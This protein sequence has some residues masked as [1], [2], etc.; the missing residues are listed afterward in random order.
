MSEVRRTDR[1]LPRGRIPPRWS[2]CARHAA[3]ER[4]H[5]PWGSAP[6]GEISTGGRCAGLPS[7]HHPPSEFLTLST[8]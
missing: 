4:R 7:R 1:R 2:G 6:F 8:V 3:G 5:L